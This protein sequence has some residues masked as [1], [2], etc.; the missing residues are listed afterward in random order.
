GQEIAVEH[1]ARLLERLA[2][3]H[4]RQLDRKTSGLPYAA[5]DLLGA[6]AEVGVA[7]QEIAPGVDD[8]DNRLA[9][10]VCAR[11]AHLQRARAV[12]LRGEVAAAKPAMA[13]QALRTQS[14]A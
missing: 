14:R 2:H 9:A 11:V 10:E 7:R 3:R 1:A 12:A 6:R 13:P 8:A 4:H 5:L